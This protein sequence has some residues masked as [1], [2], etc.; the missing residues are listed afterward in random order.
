MA[1]KDTDPVVPPTQPRTSQGEA[2]SG[3]GDA[4]IYSRCP[5]C[6][7]DPEA[8]PFCS[9]GYH[10]EFAD[11]LPNPSTVKG[12]GKLEAPYTTPIPTLHDGSTGWVYCDNCDAP[13]PVAGHECA[14]AVAR[15]LAS[16]AALEHMAADLDHW[17]NIANANEARAELAENLL[18]ALAFD[19][20]TQQTFISF[21]GHRGLVMCRGDGPLG[22]PF[23]DA[24][25][26]GGR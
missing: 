2:A 22:C 8:T 26:G 12:T 23:C 1:T 15:A 9:N 11:S 24:A 17:V 5:T 18:T 3:L 4:S 7:D 25:R 19:H 21:A 6:N 10:A 20:G 14:S 13:Q 16:P